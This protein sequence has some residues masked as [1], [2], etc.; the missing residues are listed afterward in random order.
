MTFGLPP[1]PGNPP[2]FGCLPMSEPTAPD[3]PITVLVVEDSM[4][5]ADSIAR[6]LRVGAGYEVRVAYNGEAGV[7]MGLA[8]PPNVV[9]CDLGLPEM[10]GLEVCRSIRALPT[11]DQPVMVALTG[12]GREEDLRR[13]RE[14]GF[15]DHLVKPVAADKLEALLRSVAE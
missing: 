14:A 6:F 8:D 12:W 2:A 13:T 11:D 9:L 5:V 10:D 1:G 7:K 15:D 4:D 3:K